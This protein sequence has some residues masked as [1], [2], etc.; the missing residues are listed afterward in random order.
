MAA[1]SYERRFRRALEERSYV[2][3][4][5]YIELGHVLGHTRHSKCYRIEITEDK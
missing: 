2:I 4:H 5:Q 3:S 1:A